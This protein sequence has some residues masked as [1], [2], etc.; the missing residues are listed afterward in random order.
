MDQVQGSGQH[1]ELGG[2]REGGEE[3]HPEAEGGEALIEILSGENSIGG[4]FVRIRDG[5][6]TLVFDQGIRFDIMSRYYSMQVTPQGIA[7]LRRLGVIPKQEWYMDASGIYISHMHLDHLGLL[8]NIPSETRVYLPS[9]SVYEDMKERWENSSSWLQLVAGRYFLEIREIKPLEEDENG[10]IPLP[11]SHSAYPAYAFL[12]FGRE[13]TILYTGDFRVDSFLGEE[14][15]L[16]L[17]GEDLLTYL[18]ENPDVRVDTLIIE[19]TNVGSNRTPISPDDVANMIRRIA[20]SQKSSQAPML[21][22]LHGLDFEYAYLILEI[23]KELGFDCYVASAQI[24]KLLERVPE[25]PVEINLVEDFVRYPTMREKVSL[26]EIG[27]NS[28]ILTSHREIVDLL[29]DPSFRPAMRSPVAVLSEPEP[30]VEE[31]LE[32]DVIANWLS[33]MGV[34]HYRMRASGHYYPYQLTRIMS[35]VR[36]KDVKPIHTK[37][38]DLLKR[39]ASL[40]YGST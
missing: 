34:Q 15:F 20:I 26:E 31:A 10:V 18:G 27:G 22:T 2:I 12:Y 16:E 39:L 24:A 35:V 38:P 14:R 23:A 32:Y 25:P 6:K 21:F 11:V 17:I 36:P 19:G 9:L 33:A 13:E 28:F 7:E 29:R 30:E 4:N 3:V 5:D 1:H 40:S 37:S 8:H